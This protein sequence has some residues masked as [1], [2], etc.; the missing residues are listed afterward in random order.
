MQ[1]VGWTHAATNPHVEV[2]VVDPKASV[3][4]LPTVG[5]RV[6]ATATMKGMGRVDAD[7][8][9][10]AFE[11]HRRLLTGIAYRI[12]G[13]W[14]E[15]E[16]LIQDVWPR[17]ETNAADVESPEGW[18]RRVTVRAAIDR[19]RR[20]QRRR[21]TYPGPWL[22]EPVAMLPD[23]AQ[24]VEDRDSVSVGM[25]LVLET[26]SPL[27]RA[28]FVLRQGFDW[29]HEEIGDVLGRSATTVRQLDHRARRHV[30]DRRPRYEADE[31]T[32]RA[33]AESF[34][35]ACLNGD[36]T[37]LLA[38]LAPGVVLHSDA[39]GEARAPRRPI[40]EAKKVRVVT[41]YAAQVAGA[42]GGRSVDPGAAG[43]AGRTARPSHRR[44]ARIPRAR[45]ARDRALHHSPAATTSSCTWPT[46]AR[47]ICNGWSSTSSPSAAEVARVETRLIFS[48][49][50]GGPPVRYSRPDPHRGAFV[51]PT[52]HTSKESRP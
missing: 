11:G 32:A 35:R 49:W 46:A 29:S 9:A 4:S 28:V 8:V 44:P 20:L 7:A 31:T 40:R 38:M 24:V 45:L 47:Q 51:P 34:L 26:L 5:R 15:A 10:A 1:S 36:V 6:D 42:A 27:E 41:G 18:L 23:P 12:L 37:G 39:G 17:W 13:S 52:P 2:N 19:L 21:E 22:P 25:L 48:T 16:D 33:T 30:A 3:S 50:H 14:T 43:R